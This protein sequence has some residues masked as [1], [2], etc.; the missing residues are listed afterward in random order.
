[1]AVLAGVITVTLCLALITVIDLPAE[2]GGAAL[3]N[4][5]HGPAV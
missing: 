4:V 3:F 2:R 5:L 1:V